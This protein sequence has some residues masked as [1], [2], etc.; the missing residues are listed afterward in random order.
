[1]SDGQFKILYNGGNYEGSTC[2]G[3]ITSIDSVFFDRTWDNNGKCH[4][5]VERHALN[6]PAARHH[7][8]RRGVVAQIQNCLNDGGGHFV[9]I[10]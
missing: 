10:T 9:A 3:I 1:M 6:I 7:R 2:D 4:T 5:T 8:S